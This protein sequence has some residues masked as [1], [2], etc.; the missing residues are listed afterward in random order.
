MENL[1]GEWKKE[2]IKV[3]RKIFL[4]SLIQA[5]SQFIGKKAQKGLEKADQAIGEKVKKKKVKEEE[6]EVEETEEAPKPKKKRTKKPTPVEPV[7]DASPEPQE[8]PENV[9]D[10]DVAEEAPE[11]E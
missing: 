2:I 10:E 3:I 6:A 11:A 1:S 9:A 4:E 5:S 8:A 7:Q